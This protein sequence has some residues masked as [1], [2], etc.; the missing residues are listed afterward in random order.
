M[1]E[2]DLNSK[3]ED[4]D[5]FKPENGSVTLRL[6]ASVRIT[7][8]VKKK[9]EK[10]SARMNVYATVKVNVSP[11]VSI[12]ASVSLSVSVTIIVTESVNVRVSSIV[13]VRENVNYA[14]YAQEVS[15]T[16]KPS[17]TPIGQ[18]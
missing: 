9:V 4:E 5:L 1:T 8:V 16:Y 13:R 12:H 14:F 15:H 10:R 18:T 2:I 6:H 7:A 3:L 17:L 11:S